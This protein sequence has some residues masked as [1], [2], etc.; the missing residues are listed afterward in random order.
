MKMA[1]IIKPLEKWLKRLFKINGTPIEDL[2]DQVL[3][4]KT[5]VSKAIWV[6]FMLS[7]SFWKWRKT[8]SRHCSCPVL[9]TQRQEKDT[10]LKKICLGRQN[11]VIK[12]SS[13]AMNHECSQSLQ[14]VYSSEKSDYKKETDT[15]NLC[16]KYIQSKAKYIC[17]FSRVWKEE[18]VFLSHGL[19]HPLLS[20]T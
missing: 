19:G 18:I 8:S 3:F 15:F 11:V 1:T 13:V 6:C 7:V 4:V 5:S 20:K 10:F 2:I 12:A 16:F 14:L 17:K 9:E